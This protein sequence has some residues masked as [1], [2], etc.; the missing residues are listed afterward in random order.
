[1][2]AK[3]F[4]RKKTKPEDGFSGVQRSN[5]TASQRPQSNQQLQQLVP[6][7]PTRPK[8]PE[9]HPKILSIMDQEWVH[10]VYPLFLN[11]LTSIATTPG[12]WPSRT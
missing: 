2:M 5:T 9:F 6:Q 11:M 10:Q 8:E 12:L 1:M 7:A 4:L 3:G